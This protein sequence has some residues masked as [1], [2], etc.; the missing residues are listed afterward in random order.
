METNIGA[1]MSRENPMDRGL[2]SGVA[3]PPL[4]AHSGTDSDKGQGSGLPNPET[5]TEE[6]SA[7]TVKMEWDSFAGQMEMCTEDSSAKM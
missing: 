2:I 7:Q 4:L 3:E 1:I 6:T 5:N